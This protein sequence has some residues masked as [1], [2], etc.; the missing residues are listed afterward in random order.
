MTLDKAEAAQALADIDRSQR[1]SSSLYGYSRAAPYIFIAGV[2]WLVADLTLQFSRLRS[3]LVWSVVGALG[4]IAMFVAG[5][6]QNRHLG[7]AGDR[8]EGLRAAGVWLSMFFF[9]WTSFAVLAPS[10]GAQTHTFI[11]DFFG[12]A[13]IIAG[14]W[15]GWRLVALGVALVG[16]SLIGF[17]E[18]HSYYLA[19]MGV[20]GGGALMLGGLWLRAA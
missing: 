5:Y 2:M 3:D 13:Y 9:F 1:R 15:R 8:K 10:S 19:Y 4:G 18:V 17:Y 16:L 11:S 7:P 14:L 12:F 20:V 6:L